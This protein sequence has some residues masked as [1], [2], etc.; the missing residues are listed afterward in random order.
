MIGSSVKSQTH[1]QQALT[2]WN[3][4]VPCDALHCE[5]DSVLLF[6]HNWHRRIITLR[7]AGAANLSVDQ[8][9]EPET[10]ARSLVASRATGPAESFRNLIP[11]L[12]SSVDSSLPAFD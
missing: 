7:R 12:D 11:R 6:S 3:L 8:T 1:Q 5:H 4:V 10:P 9:S 2:A